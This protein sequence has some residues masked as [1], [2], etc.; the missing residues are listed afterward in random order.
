MR[1]FVPA[2]ASCPKGRRSPAYCA[3]RAPT[4]TL[5]GVQVACE[6][7]LSELAAR[8]QGVYERQ[9]AR[10]DAERPKGLHE[11]S[12]LARF[13]DLLPPGGTILDL[14]CGAGDPFHAWF[15]AQGFRVT[16]IDFAAA[17]IEIARERFPEGDWR[18]ADMRTLD[19]ADRF[20]GI[21]GWNSFF[22]LTQDEQRT[23]LPKLVLGISDRAA[24]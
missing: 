8:T 4:L 12:W 11:R 6:S 3:L 7:S 10:F 19:L 24:F 23:T 16:G 14:G 17:M 15:R 22:H 1:G 2:F 9:A 5:R 20:D 21:L 18:V 13:A